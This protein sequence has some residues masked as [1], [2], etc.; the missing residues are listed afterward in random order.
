MADSNGNI[1]GRFSELERAV[2]A[3]EK[4]AAAI[5]LKEEDKEEIFKFLGPEDSKRYMG[6]KKIY[7]G[8]T[9][10]HQQ[11]VARIVHECA[12]AISELPM[13][14]IG[15]HLSLE[16]IE[17]IAFGARVHDIGKIMWGAQMHYLPSPL[18]KS[19]LDEKSM[20]MYKKHALNGW[21][22]VSLVNSNFG[23]EIVP[24]KALEIPI[25]II[26]QHGECYNGKG[27]PEGL[28]R[29]AISFE[30]RIFGVFDFYMAMVENRPYRNR[31]HT[32]EETLDI[33][34]EES[35]KRF[36][37]S[38]L[39]PIHKAL[40]KN[41]LTIKEIVKEAQDLILSAQDTK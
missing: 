2:S 21:G 34:L 23:R 4:E 15:Q 29:D 12:K 11:T 14:E 13:P 10:P 17:A 37:P 6:I 28:V 8:L 25:N 18:F 33:L 41:A 9:V 24:R 7:L 32:H 30:A 31:P 38:I 22:L 36:D 5:T 35:G 26:R 19:N 39:D 3:Y 27:N 1:Y 16:Q 20:E 40:D